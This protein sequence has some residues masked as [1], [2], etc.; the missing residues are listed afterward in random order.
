MIAAATDPLALIGSLGGP[1]PTITAAALAGKRF[2]DPRWAVPGVLPEGLSLL[3]APPKKGKSFLI[4]GVGVAVAAG[5][6]AL[7]KVQVDAGDVLY[8][9]LEDGERRLQERLLRLLDGEPASERLHLATEWPALDAGGLDRLDGWLAAHPEARLV[10]V[11]TLARVRPAPSRGGSVYLDDYAVAA[12]LKRVADRHRV[13]MVV[14]HHA[15]KAEAEDP[16]DA[17]SGTAGLAGAADA[18]LVLRREIGRANASL[19][20]RG[21]DVPE[22]DHALAFDPVTGR[23][24]L[25]GDAADYRLTEGRAAVVELLRERGP[26]APKP[27]AEALG[28]DRGNVRVTL[29]RMA[30][31]GQLVASGGTYYLPPETGVTAVTAGD[32]RHETEPHG[33]TGRVVDVTASGPSQALLLQ[34]LQVLQGGSDPR[35]VLLCGRCGLPRSGNDAPCPACGERTGRWAVPDQAPAP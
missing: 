22:A 33:V 4:L 21:R 12:D 7:G 14:V 20:V 17:V 19:Y 2:E 6:V 26:M 15:R 5:G 28:A 13:A 11:D 18:V 23:W 10:A 16:L 30:Q 3:I 27:I 1:P 34:G 32:P 24:N 29:H 35:A 25:L 9:A 8:L 31:A